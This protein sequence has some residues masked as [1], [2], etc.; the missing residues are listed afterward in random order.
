MVA[1]GLFGCILLIRA[2]DIHFG[3]VYFV[4]GTA[5][6]VA[7]YKSG[8]DPVVAGLMGGVIALAYPAQR[9]DLERATDLFRL[10]REQPT[11]DL[12]RSARVALRT[13]VSPNE[14]LQSALASLDE[15]RDRPALRARER[16]RPPERRLPLDRLHLPRD[17]RDSARLRDRQ[18]DRDR[19]ARPGWRHASAAAACARRS[20][21]RRSPPRARSPGSASRSPSSS[22]ISPSTAPSSTRRRS[23]SSARRCS[24][25]RSRGSSSS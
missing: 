6:W 14:R 2:F 22:P 4:M 1:I 18:A 19:R 21:G 12:A 10:F 23:A 11:G 17:A 20:A 16:R 9:S 8:V 15:L 25:R 7:F 3:P 24:L 5:V 13:A